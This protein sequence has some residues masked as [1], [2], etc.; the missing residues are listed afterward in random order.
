MSCLL[1][2]PT[3]YFD[4]GVATTFYH[5]KFYDFWYQKKSRKLTFSVKEYLISS[6]FHLDLNKNDQ[7]PQKGHYNIQISHLWESVI[8]ILQLVGKLLHGA[9]SFKIWNRTEE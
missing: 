8:H 4:A 1:L 9:I 2:P 7:Y 6:T 5:M 3:N